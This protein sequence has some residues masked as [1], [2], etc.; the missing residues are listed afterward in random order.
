L[1]CILVSEELSSVFDKGMHGTTF[2]GNPVACAA[3]EVIIDELNDGMLQHVRAQGEYF[4]T[5]LLGVQNDYPDKVVEVRGYG[6]MLGLLLTFEASSLVEELLKRNF[7]TNAASGL[8]LRLV[9][10]FIVSKENIDNFI[11]KLR[12]SLDVL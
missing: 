1:G 11:I 4:H 6:L 5:C 2:G 3:G 7:I 8:V 10:P 9:P 12:N